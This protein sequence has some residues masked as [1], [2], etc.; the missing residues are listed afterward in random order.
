MMSIRVKMKLKK[1]QVDIEDVINEI[2]TGEL[3]NAIC[4]INILLQ[5]AIKGEPVDLSKIGR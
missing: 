3:R 1:I 5:A 4:D 2:P